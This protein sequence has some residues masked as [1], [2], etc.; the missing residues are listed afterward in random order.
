MMDWS[1]LMLGLALVA[2]AAFLFWFNRKQMK[3]PR[4]R[5]DRFARTRRGKGNGDV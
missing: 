3:R 4:E 1:W 2:L 5:W